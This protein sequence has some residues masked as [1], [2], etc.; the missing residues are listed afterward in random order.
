MSDIKHSLKRSNLTVC[1]ASPS[2]V[3]VIFNADVVCSLKEGFIVGGI[4]L[5]YLA[6]ALWVG[7]TGGW[8]YMYGAALPPAILVF[9][10]MVSGSIYICWRAFMFV[11]ACVSCPSSACL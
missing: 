2:S 11:C 7:E 6:S 9:A 5:G 1:C 8:R 10:G 4:L 3:R